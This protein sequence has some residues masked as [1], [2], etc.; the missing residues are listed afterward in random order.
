MNITFNPI[1]IRSVASLYERNTA[2]GSTTK[3]S[4]WFGD[5]DRVEDLKKALLFAVNC[6][7][8]DKALFILKQLQV[9]KT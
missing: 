4:D 5:I 6:G 9:L 8:F 1:G 2:V 3:A 7:D